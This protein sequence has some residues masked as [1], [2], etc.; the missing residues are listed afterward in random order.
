MTHPDNIFCVGC[1]FRKY[2]FLKTASVWVA[3]LEN[4]LF[5]KFVSGQLMVLKTQQFSLN[6]LLVDKIYFGTLRF[7]W[8]IQKCKIQCALMA[9]INSKYV[10]NIKC[11]APIKSFIYKRLKATFDKF[12]LAE[13][14]Y[15]CFCV[16]LKNIT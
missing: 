12:S 14:T 10:W 11:V 16:F 13:I 6:W 2:H 9:L 1:I 7:K 4:I 3:F 8:I 5:W 15:K